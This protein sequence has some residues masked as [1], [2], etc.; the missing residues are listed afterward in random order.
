MDT[1]DKETGKA[2]KQI[3]FHKPTEEYQQQLRLCQ[4]PK[5]EGN[6]SD[7]VVCP[8]DGDVHRRT[9][10][11]RGGYLLALLVFLIS[12]PNH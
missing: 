10:R 9:A 4:R 2:L 8:Q 7:W 6:I 5:N 11:A 12:S 1:L 3:S